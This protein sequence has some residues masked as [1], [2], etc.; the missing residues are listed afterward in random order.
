MQPQGTTPEC[1]A[2]FI[3]CPMGMQIPCCHPNPDKLELTIEF[4][5]SKPQSYNVGVNKHCICVSFI[6][7]IPK[8]SDLKIF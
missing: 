7:N 1:L 8:L 5:D 3:A 2:K 4:G 6:V